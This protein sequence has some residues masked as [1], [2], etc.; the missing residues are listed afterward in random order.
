MFLDLA[1]GADILGGMPTIWPIIP[2][3]VRAVFSDRADE[4]SLVSARVLD[5]Q[6][7][8]MCHG[9]YPFR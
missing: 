8:R 4:N 3:S 2:P 5:K 1:L 9:L 6:H 7:R